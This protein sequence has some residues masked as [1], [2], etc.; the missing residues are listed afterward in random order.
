MG[1]RPGDGEAGGGIDAVGDPLDEDADIGAIDS[2]P[3]RFEKIKE[4]VAAGEEEGAEIFQ[5][6]CRLPGWWFAPTVFTN[7]AQATGWLEEIFGPVC[8]C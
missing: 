3:T 8:P 7:V 4:L 5:P 6:P 1:A 2:E